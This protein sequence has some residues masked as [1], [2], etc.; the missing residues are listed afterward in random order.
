MLHVLE[1]LSRK[2]EGYRYRRNIVRALALHRRGEIR[3]DGLVPSSVT[4]RLEMEWRARDIHPWDRRILSPAE[5]A[6]AFVQ[7]SLAD[8]EA[9]VY[10]LF[11]ALPQVDV[12]ALRVFDPTS[13][14]LIISGSVSRAD[15]LARNEGIS[16]GMRLRYLGL[17][18]HLGGSQFEALDYRPLHGAPASR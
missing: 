17:T 14:N 11:A 4:T 2:L 16:I 5:R 18:Y 3:R 6:A 1:K 13:G 10:R 15:T 12:I 8:T 7:Q 9:A